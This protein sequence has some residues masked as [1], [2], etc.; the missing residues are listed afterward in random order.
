[1]EF[2]SFEGRC[3]YCGNIVPIMAADQKDADI[4]VAEDCS[5]DGSAKEKRFEDA[6][7]LI[8]KYFS[9]SCIDDGLRAADGKVVKLMYTAAEL[10]NN[11]LIDKVSISVDSLTK[12]IISMSSKAIIKVQ[13]IDV[14]KYE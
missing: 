14:F 13:R 12:C 8:I 10:V 2:D 5:C 4:K 7:A 9:D 1:M 11:G 3:E 6:K